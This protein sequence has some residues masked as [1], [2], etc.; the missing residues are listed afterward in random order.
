MTKFAMPYWIFSN[1]CC[2]RPHSRAQKMAK[3]SAISWPPL[4][5]YHQTQKAKPCK[6][7]SPKSSSQIKLNAMPLLQYLVSAA[8]SVQRSTQATVIRLFQSTSEPSQP[9]ALLICDTQPAGGKQKL[10]L[11]K[12]SCMSTLHMSSNIGP[13]YTAWISQQKVACDPNAAGFP[14]NVDFQV[15]LTMSGK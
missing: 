8:F 15:L 13:I 4:L 1:S 14:G 3:F 12:R 11:T 7:T 10:A 6:R 2:L 5:R 9:V